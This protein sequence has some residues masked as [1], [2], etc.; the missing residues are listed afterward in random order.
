MQRKPKVKR[1]PTSEYAKLFWAS[2][3]ILSF[4]SHIWLDLTMDLCWTFSKFAGH[5]RW[6]RRISRTLLLR[7]MCQEGTVGIFRYL[8]RPATALLNCFPLNSHS[9]EIE[10]FYPGKYQAFIKGVI[11]P[12]SLITVSNSCVTLSYAK[13]LFIYCRRGGDVSNVGGSMK[14]IWGKRGGVQ[15]IL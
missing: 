8:N 1:Q 2:P 9:H 6:V 5:V 13:G 11:A 15:I 7:V 10:K 4:S 12:C 3:D 14:I